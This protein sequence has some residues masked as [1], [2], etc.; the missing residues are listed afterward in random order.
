M[1]LQ[2][3]QKWSS[4]SELWCEWFLYTFLLGW[5]DAVNTLFAL[6]S[7][8]QR[9]GATRLS[10]FVYTAISPCSK[11]HFNDRQQARPNYCTSKPYFCY[12]SYVE[13]K[14]F[15]SFPEKNAG[16]PAPLQRCYLERQQ[17]AHFKSKSCFHEWVNNVFCPAATKSCAIKQAIWDEYSCKILNRSSTNPS[18]GMPTLQRKWD[19]LFSMCPLA[20]VTSALGTASCLLCHLSMCHETPHAVL[21]PVLLPPA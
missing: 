4:I 17:W 19:T 21:C 1:L 9:E 8:K 18:T 5:Q 6:Q 15:F 7:F 14:G 16:F 11:I 2:N 12:L 3:R 10:S 13:S 20:L